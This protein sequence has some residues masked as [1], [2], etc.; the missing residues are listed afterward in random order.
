MKRLSLSQQKALTGYLF[1]LPFIIGFI[2]F[3]LAPFI[4]G[5]IFSMNRLVIVKGGYELHF[6]KWENYRY[7]L[8]VDAKFIPTFAAT[9]LNMLLDVPA[10][11]FF[12]FFAAVLLN[13]KF[14]GRLLARSIFFLPVILGSGV[15]LSLEQTDYM[16]SMLE[17]SSNAITGFM[18]GPALTNFLMELKI[19]PQ[20]MIYVISV[21]ERVPEVIR[22][23]GIQILIFLA[24]LQSI[25]GSLYEAAKVEGASGWQSF[26]MITLPIMS[27][28]ILA[29]V[30]YSIVDSFLAANNEL[31]VYIRATAFGG[32]G[33]GIGTAMGVMYFAA[34]SVVLAVVVGIMSRWVFYQ[35]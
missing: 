27:P 4:Q 16:W 11:I 7:A 13:H 23:S 29:N 21:V 32:A 25:S 12:A 19:P 9:F 2:L 8:Q 15:V 20:M 33:F 1:S 14:K 3:F 31:V 26:W 6:I 28:I 17:Q 5:L 10:I 30:V 22:A 24:G 35:E 18:S 34:V